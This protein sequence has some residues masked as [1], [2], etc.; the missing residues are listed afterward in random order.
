MRCSSPHRHKN[1]MKEDDLITECPQHGRLQCHTG[2][3]G[4]ALRRDGQREEKS[5]WEPL[6]WFG[7]EGEEEQFW[8]TPQS[9]ILPNKVC[10]R[11]K[12]FNKSLPDWGRETPTSSSSCLP[13]GGRETPNNN[14]SGFLVGEGK[15]QTRAILSHLRS[16]GKSIVWRQRVPERG[17]PD[18]RL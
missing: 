1:V 10:P 14:P 8:K 15:Q 18:H 16:R 2:P 5:K 3:H 17:G 11:D 13:S 7:G 9:S 4:G 6:L 12:L